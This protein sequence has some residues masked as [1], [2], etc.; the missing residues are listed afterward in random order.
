MA[1]SLRAGIALLA[2]ADVGGTAETVCLVCA[3]GTVKSGSPILREFP[4]GEL[5]A[6]EMAR[7]CVQDVRTQCTREG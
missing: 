2:S 4:P 1:W 6:M 5:P 7:P 3:L